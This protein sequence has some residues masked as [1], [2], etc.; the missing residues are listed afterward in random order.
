MSLDLGKRLEA[1]GL[2]RLVADSLL[3]YLSILE[4]WSKKLD[5]VAPAPTDILF[6]RH[7][8]DSAIAW[9]AL[10]ESKSTLVDGPIL[11]VGSGAGLPG[12]VWAICSGRETILLEPREKRC[13]FLSQVSQQ[14]RLENIEVSRGR[15]EDF[16]R[17]GLAIITSRAVGLSTLLLDFG[18]TSLKPGGA[19]VEMAGGQSEV[20]EAYEGYVSRETLPYSLDDDSRGRTLEVFVRA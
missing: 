14:L 3:E 1:L 5:L 19:V 7:I 20:P 15:L 9:R 12:V 2:S 8:Y 4:R 17:E 6:T 16:S 13:G 11:D 18:L 10:V